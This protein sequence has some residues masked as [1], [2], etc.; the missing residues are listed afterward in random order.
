MKVRIAAGVLG[1]GAMLLVPASSGYATL[2]PHQCDVLQGSIN[3]L[4][5][6]IAGWSVWA[7]VS[8]KNKLIA[9]RDALQ[10]KFTA[11]CP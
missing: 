8:A 4:N 7:P 11:N 6:T 2:T 10:A 9:K 1:L 5:T 3:Q